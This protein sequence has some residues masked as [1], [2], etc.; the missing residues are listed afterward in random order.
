LL[1]TQGNVDRIKKQL[2]GVNYTGLTL[3]LTGQ[4]D[5]LN[6]TI[7]TVGNKPETISFDPQAAV[8]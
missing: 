5:A 6:G 8:R 2:A 7:T 1:L 4:S 3:N